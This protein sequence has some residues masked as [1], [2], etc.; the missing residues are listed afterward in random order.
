M[1]TNQAINLQ[2][3]LRK[4]NWDAAQLG[5]FLG[6]GAVVVLLILGVAGVVVGFFLEF[7]LP[8]P[9]CLR[10]RSK[11]V[12]LSL[13]PNAVLNGWFVFIQSPKSP[14]WAGWRNEWGQ[15]LAVLGYGVAASL[16]VSGLFIWRRRSTELS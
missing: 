3:P 14:Y 16:I 15:S 8:I 6:A 10:A 7:I 5:I 1:P 11:V 13:I 4:S 9:V 12:M 2:T